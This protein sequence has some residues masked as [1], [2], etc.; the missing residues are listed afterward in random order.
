MLGGRTGDAETA[1][2]G[3]GVGGFVQGGQP[4]FQQPHKVV[5]L[6]EG[7]GRAHRQ[8][9]QQ[10][11]AGGGA[12]GDDHSAATG[13]P[14]GGGGH[15]G[16]DRGAAAARVVEIQRQ[17]VGAGL[18]GV[19]VGRCRRLGQRLGEPGGGTELAGGR[20]VDA[21]RAAAWGAQKRGEGL[22]DLL[23]AVGARQHR[24]GGR[25]AHS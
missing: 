2:V 21:H 14:F 17:Q 11:R 16:L 23:G 20:V 10:V 5:H 12:V 3:V 1:R 24:R 7:G 19:Q 13:D 9:A 22:P 25:L 6:V 4:G 15:V 8:R 18:G